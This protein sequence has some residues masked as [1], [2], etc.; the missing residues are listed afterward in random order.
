MFCLCIM[1]PGRDHLRLGLS[2]TRPAWCHTD[3]RL[4][5]IWAPWHKSGGLLRLDSCL[6]SPE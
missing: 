2:P 5:P 3:F 4:G 6:G 1:I